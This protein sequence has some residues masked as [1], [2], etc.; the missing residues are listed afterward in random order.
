[1]NGDNPRILV[2][3]DDFAS[4]ILMRTILLAENY[5]NVDVFQDSREAQASYQI[6]KYDIVIVDLRMPVISGFDILQ[7]LQ[8]RH[9]NK[10]AIIVLTA[11]VEA[12]TENKALDLGARKVFIKPFYIPEYIH[13]VNAAV[14]QLA[15]PNS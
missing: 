14:K 6:R 13:E 12:G 15:G 10:V 1:M 7:D 4:L 8:D 11:N 2:V 3:D 9:E 5:L